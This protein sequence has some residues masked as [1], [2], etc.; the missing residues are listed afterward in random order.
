MLDARLSA[1]FTFARPQPALI[2]YRRSVLYYGGVFVMRLLRMQEGK[3]AQHPIRSPVCRAA[4]RP[5]DPGRDLSNEGG[6]CEGAGNILP[7]NK[8]DVPYTPAPSYL[9]E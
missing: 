1:Q 2:S 4:G 8:C 6:S 3:P 7:V 5:G 9:K